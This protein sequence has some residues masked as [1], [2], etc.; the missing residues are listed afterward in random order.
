MENLIILFH[1]LT[2][3]AIIGLILLQQGKGAEMGASFGG[4]A[5]QTLFG[6]GGSG[7]FFAKMTALAAVVFFVTSFSLAVIAKQNAGIGEDDVPE[8]EEV[9]VEIESTDDLPEVG[10][11]ASV[12]DI[13][14]LVEDVVEAAEDIPDAVE[15]AA[16]APEVPEE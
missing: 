10:D 16:P 13:P 2:A 15:D 1:V 11:T 14:E 4:G 6:S 9:P 3:L 7:N 12:D 5:S 8:V